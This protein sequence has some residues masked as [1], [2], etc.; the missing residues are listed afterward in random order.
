MD[1]QMGQDNRILEGQKVLT[2]EDKNSGKNF[3]F[4]NSLEKEK[5]SLK[6]NYYVWLSRLFIFFAGVSCLFMV[7]ASLSLFR[8]SSLVNIEPFLVLGSNSSTEIVRQEPITPNMVSKNMLMETFIRQYI[9][10][11]NTI[12][13]DA[14]EMRSRWMPG[15][16]VNFLSAPG[17]YDEFYNN[18]LNLLQSY[19]DQRLTREVEIISVKRQ[20]TNAN[21]RI[22]KVDFTTF[23]LFRGTGSG[24]GYLSFKQRYWT[25]SIESR[26]IR[27]RTFVGRRLINPIGFTVINYS[28]TEVNI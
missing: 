26:F 24:D 25:A 27:G 14:T 3:T 8:L 12:I 22:W 15:G 20:G 1:K 13:D 2:I 18:S 28:Q 17:V 7:M 6:L 11:S 23:D 4:I 10:V 9:I 16:M 21:S 5:E 19:Q